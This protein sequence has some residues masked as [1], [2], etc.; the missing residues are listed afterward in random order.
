MPPRPAESE[1]QRG[2]ERAVYLD[3]DTYYD[4]RDM[5]DELDDFLDKSDSAD[6][7][8]DTD[9]VSSLVERT[10]GILREVMW[11]YEDSQQVATSEAEDAGGE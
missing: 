11:K 2:P 7:S 6:T 8:T 4:L 9:R 10:A 1:V 5:A 3:E